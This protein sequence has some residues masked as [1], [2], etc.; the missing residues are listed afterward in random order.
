MNKLQ[1]YNYEEN[2]SFWSIGHQLRY[3]LNHFRVDNKE[4]IDAQTEQQKVDAS[5]MRT[6]QTTLFG[7]LI[8]TIKSLFGKSN[9]AGETTESF[10]EMVQ[11]ENDETQ[12]YLDA[13][14]EAAKTSNEKLSGIINSLNAISDD[15]EANTS[16]DAANAQKIKEAISNLKTIVLP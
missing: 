5:E 2:S 16:G 1:D 14:K 11:R 4:A 7:N 9:A 3:D 8:K 13:Q 15:I 10:Y 12:K 6:N